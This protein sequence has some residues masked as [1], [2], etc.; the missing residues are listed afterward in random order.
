[1]DTENRTQE[2]DFGL[3]DEELWELELNSKSSVCEGGGEG[4]SG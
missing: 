2:L 3:T 1:M 4:W